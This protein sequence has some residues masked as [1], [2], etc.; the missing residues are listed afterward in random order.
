MRVL[1]VEDDLTT[2]RGVTL[3]LKTQG[4]IVDA[5]DTGDHQ[6][7]EIRV[8]EGRMRRHELVDRRHAEEMRQADR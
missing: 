6:P 5:A 7:R 4:M 1:L 3:M 8:R 2:A